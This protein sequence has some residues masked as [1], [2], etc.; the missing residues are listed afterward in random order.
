MIRSIWESFWCRKIGALQTTR[1]LKTLNEHQF[2][3]IVSSGLK[4]NLGTGVMPAWHNNPNID[5]YLEDLWAYLKA[6]ADGALGLGRSEKRQTSSSVGSSVKTADQPP[7]RWARDIETRW[8]SRS[9]NHGPERSDGG[10]AIVRLSN[11]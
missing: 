11:Q 10:K 6:R 3:T 9:T 2:Q 8:C 5:P 4:G 7:R 1:M